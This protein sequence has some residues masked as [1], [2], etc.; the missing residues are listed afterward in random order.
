MSVANRP[1]VERKLSE[2]KVELAPDVQYRLETLFPRRKGSYAAHTIRR[3]AK[4]LGQLEPVLRDMLLSGEV[5]QF[6]CKGKQTASNNT[7]F[8]GVLCDDNIKLHT[9]LVMTNLRLLCIQTNH[10]GIPKRTFWSVFYSQIK[11]VESGITDE[12]T[13]E[14]SDGLFLSYYEFSQ[15]EILILKQVIREMSARFEANHFDPPALQSWEQLC[16]HCYQIVPNRE[17]ECENCR[18]QFW[19]PGEIAIRCFLFPPWGTWILGHYG[20]ALWEVLVFFA[21]LAYDFH[22]I[23]RGDFSTALVFLIFGNSLAALLTSRNAAKGLYLKED[24]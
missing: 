19:S 5:V 2:L 9:A 24:V 18:A 23:R 22:S 12:V 3:R 4:L 1:A 14:L 13:L 6:I 21:I 10:R 16:G 17:Y 11:K 7:Y 8:L 15:D 20:V